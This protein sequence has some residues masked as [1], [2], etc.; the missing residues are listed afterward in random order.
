MLEKVHGP[1]DWGQREKEVNL[2]CPRHKAATVAEVASDLG[3]VTGC[4]RNL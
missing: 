3:A 4:K 1:R 2:Q